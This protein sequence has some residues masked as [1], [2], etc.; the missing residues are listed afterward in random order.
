MPCKRVNIKANT[1]HLIPK[2]AT[3]AIVPYRY[4]DIF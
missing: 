1:Y 3:S 4:C 2:Q